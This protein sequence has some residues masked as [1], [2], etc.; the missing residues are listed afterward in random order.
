MNSP[1]SKVFLFDVDNTLLNN[2]RVTADLKEHLRE[3]VGEACATQYWVFFE[4]LRKERGYADY[5]GA[6]QRFRSENPQD[7][8]FIKISSFL[9]G[10][11]F[12]DRVYP[13]AKEAIWHCRSHGL[14]AILSDGDVVF[15]PW[16]IMRSGLFDAV[17]ERALI[18]VHKEHE[19]AQVEAELPAEHYVLVDD[20]VRI[21]TAVKEIWKD[22][23][24]TV[25]VRQGHYALDEA[26][27]A[28]YPKAD[29]T[30]EAIGDLRE[31]DPSEL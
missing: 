1:V 22:R 25:F 29:V 6:L 24:T 10:Y 20:K 9:L 8:D 18:Y 2:D 27:V 19:L 4:D 21:L 13:G 15:Q 28:Q 30:I 12:P 31:L 16:K 7:R 3:A 17:E 14:T 26:L 5:L 11:P 23:V